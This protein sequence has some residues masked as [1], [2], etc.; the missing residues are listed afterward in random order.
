MLGGFKLAYPTLETEGHAHPPYYCACY[1][2][3]R[4]RA[5]CEPKWGL[6]KVHAMVSSITY[7]GR[8]MLLEAT[9]AACNFRAIS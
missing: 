7:L 2:A 5:A 9:M 3:L 4:M 1:H 8:R 6:C